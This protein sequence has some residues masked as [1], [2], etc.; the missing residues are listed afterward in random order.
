MRFK[1]PQVKYSETPEPVTPYQA[2]GQIWDQR[3]GSARVQASNWRLMA[4][5][6]LS[7]ALLLAGALAW[8]TGQSL[9]TPYVVEV[10]SAG[11][12]RAVGEAATPYQPTD[13]QIAF[14]LAR[15]ITDVRSLSIDPIVVRQ[16]WLEAYDYATD[17]GAATLND[18]ARTNDPFARVGQNSAAVEVT[19]VV[20][21]SDSS[22]QAR[23]IEHSYVA[24][25]L[26]G[27]E[28]WT[29]MLTVVIQ[30]PR[31]EERL[32]RNPLGIYVNGLSWSRELGSAEGRKP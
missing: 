25:T 3:L 18:Y 6:C 8:R 29:A 22:F 2:A 5:G 15:F 32:R 28:R 12:V 7:L 23:W 24:G 4:F 1:R 31:S 14:H 30:P 16:N 26:S 11:Q 10:D 20:R 13:A 21:M 9:V 17:R 27:T 19:S